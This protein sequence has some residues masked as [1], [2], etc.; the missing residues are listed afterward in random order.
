[1]TRLGARVKLKELLGPIEGFAGAAL[2]R[3]DPEEDR[4]CQ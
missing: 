1:M 3:N 4:L 2:D